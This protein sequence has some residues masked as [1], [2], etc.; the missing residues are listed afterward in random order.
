MKMM[1]QEK[2]KAHTLELCGSHLEVATDS[3]LLFC[4]WRSHGPAKG[5]KNCAKRH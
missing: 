2:G 5:S 3:Q 1:E 4:H